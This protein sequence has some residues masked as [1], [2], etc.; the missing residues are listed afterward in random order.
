MDPEINTW[1]SVR[2]SAPD[3]GSPRSFAPDHPTQSPGLDHHEKDTNVIT[4]T[5]AHPHTRTP[6]HPH[7]RTASRASPTP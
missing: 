1:E 5:P 3:P 2:L 4:T 7:T 6:A